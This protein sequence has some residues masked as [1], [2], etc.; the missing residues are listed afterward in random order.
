M[1]RCTNSILD[2]TLCDKVCDLRQVGGFLRVLQV[3]S[4]NNTDRHDIRNGPFNFKG[5]E[6]GYGFLLKNIF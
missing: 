2:T 1:T 5:V 6:G 4:T 3:S